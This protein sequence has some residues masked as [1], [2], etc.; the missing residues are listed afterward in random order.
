M[1]LVL[2][3]PGSENKAA[4]LGRVGYILVVDTG[5]KNDLAHDVL[6]SVTRIRISCRRVLESPLPMLEWFL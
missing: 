2:Q 6:N 3:V 1:G 4:E 5:L